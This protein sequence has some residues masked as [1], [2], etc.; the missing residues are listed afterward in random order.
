MMDVRIEDYAGR[1]ALGALAMGALD[2]SHGDHGRVS[3]TVLPYLPPAPPLSKT[4]KYGRLDA[5]LPK[6]RRCAELAFDTAM[7]VF[8]SVPQMRACWVAWD[9]VLRDG[10]FLEDRVEQ[11]RR[12]FFGR[13]PYCDGRLDLMFGRAADELAEP[14]RG[15]VGT[16]I[17]RMRFL[18][19]RVTTPYGQKPNAWGMASEAG[20]LLVACVEVLGEPGWDALALAVD[21]CRVGRVGD[22]IAA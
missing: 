2:A 22:T 3:W 17:F 5:D 8:L 15:L 1:G 14:Q 13:R 12:A 9:G 16:V 7:T 20:S 19:H 6:A 21:I 18:A 10:F 11:H 4:E